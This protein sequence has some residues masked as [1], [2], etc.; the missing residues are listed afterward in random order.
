MAGHGKSFVS[1]S[2]GKAKQ[3]IGI[4]VRSCGI[5][6]ICF[7]NARLSKAMAKRRLAKA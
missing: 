1:Y 2:I 4:D 3:G 6:L 5:D 7:G